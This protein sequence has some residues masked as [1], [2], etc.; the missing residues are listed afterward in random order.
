[1]RQEERQVLKKK[2]IGR[3]IFVFIA[4]IV[5][6][7]SSFVKTKIQGFFSEEN[8]DIVLLNEIKVSLSG[9]YIFSGFKNNL[10]FFNNNKVSSYDFEGNRKDI[11]QF[12][13][14]N[15]FAF[16][17]G[18]YIYTGDKANGKVVA[19]RSDGTQLWSFDLGKGIDEALFEGNA[20]IILTDINTKNG[21]L[22]IF[23]RNGNYLVEKEIKGG[24]VLCVEMSMN[25]KEFIV[26]TINLIDEELVSTLS[27]MSLSGDLI[28]SEKFQNEIIHEIATTKDNNIIVVTDKKIYS[29]T[30]KKDL[31][32][33]KNIDG[34]L[35]DIKIDNTLDNIVVLTGGNNGYLEVINT[36]GR[37]EY[38]EKVDSY[39]E[40][41][42]LYDRKILLVGENKILGFNQ[43]DEFLRYISNEDLKGIYVVNDKV[44]VLI[45][46]KIKIMKMVSK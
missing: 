24:Q 2:K 26:A 41:V 15:P 18:Q 25:M 29:I 43:G 34:E 8:K 5:I 36:N 14:S 33:S 11:K 20:L 31:V 21:K 10:L 30:D 12:D 7:S 37:T 6:F 44:C 32:W 13:Y 9:D 40:K 16:I 27:M 45:D 46:D 28:W 4:L 3:F 39:Y 1:M 23:D 35:R 22:H 17:E 42:K 38:K 19:V